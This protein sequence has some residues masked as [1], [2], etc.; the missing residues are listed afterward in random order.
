MAKEVWGT[1]L[2]TQKWEFPT[3]LLCHTTYFFI[4]FLPFINS[5]IEHM[6]IL[7]AALLIKK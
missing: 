7:S 6:T 5:F 4:L 2:T 3:L 1:D